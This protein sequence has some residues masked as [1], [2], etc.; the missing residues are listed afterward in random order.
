M[1]D[2]A[3]ANASHGKTFAENLREQTKLHLASASVVPASKTSPCFAYWRSDLMQCGASKHD[4]ELVA[5]SSGARAVKEHFAIHKTRLA[6]V[7]AQGGN[8]NVVTD[9]KQQSLSLEDSFVVA[10]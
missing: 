7:L 10:P 4:S 5:I 1:P 8:M 9:L 2:E 6:K 3:A